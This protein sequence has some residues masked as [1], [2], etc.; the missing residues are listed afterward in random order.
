MKPSDVDILTTLYVLETISLEEDRRGHERRATNVH[1]CCIKID[2]LLKIVR[3]R[4]V[5]RLVD[6]E[7]DEDFGDDEE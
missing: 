1:L 6:Y 3:A 7:D 4:D 5:D 2:D